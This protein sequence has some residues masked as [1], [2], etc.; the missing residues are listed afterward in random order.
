M[1]IDVWQK[2]CNTQ[3]YVHTFFLEQYCLVDVFLPSVQIRLYVNSK[4]RCKH[5]KLILEGFGPLLSHLFYLPK[6]AQLLPVS[7]RLTSY[8]ITSEAVKRGSPYPEF[9]GLQVQP[10]HSYKSQ[11]PVL[12][13]ILASSGVALCQQRFQIC[14]LYV[15]FKQ[16][17]VETI[18]E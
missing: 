8:C 5:L 13:L 1:E 14:L 2:K 10:L 18:S 7:E 4:C 3:F 11:Y 9:I 16:W 12:L 17:L 6:W 15:H